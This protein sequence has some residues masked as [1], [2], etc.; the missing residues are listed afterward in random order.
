MMPAGGRENV[1]TFGHGAIL[2]FAARFSNLGEISIQTAGN[3]GEL[4]RISHR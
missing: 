1:V 3:L 4:G 2:V